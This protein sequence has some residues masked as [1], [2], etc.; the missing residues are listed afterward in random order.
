MCEGPSFEIVVVKFV[1]AEVEAEL[2]FEC[3]QV[4]WQM[5]TKA[6]I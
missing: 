6:K 5:L 4:R 3:S 2:N 1:V